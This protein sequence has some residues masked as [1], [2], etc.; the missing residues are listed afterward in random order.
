MVAVI[1]HLSLST[2]S[3]LVTTLW[4]QKA[5]QVYRQRDPIPCYGTC[6]YQNRTDF[7][8]GG[9]ERIIAVIK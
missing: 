3:I 2:S 4:Q 9:A 6:T 1:V 8:R 5:Y 7:D